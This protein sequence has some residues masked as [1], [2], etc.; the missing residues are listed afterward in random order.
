MAPQP[1]R[2]ASSSLRHNGVTTVALEATGVYAHVLFCTK[3][4]EGFHAIITP[5]QFA[6]QI[7]GRP[8]TDRLDCQWLSRLHVLGLL[9]A[10][11]QLD[12][13]TQTL[14]NLVRQRANHFRLSAQ[15]I[16]RMQKA[17]LLTNLKLT[18]VSVNPP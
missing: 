9:P 16:Q 11:F 3:L 13:A 18:G 12:E 2:K 15:H 17:L 7:K 4:E 6:R 8:K 14:R 5:P 1:S 10:V